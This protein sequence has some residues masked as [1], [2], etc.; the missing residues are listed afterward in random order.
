VLKASS[1]P[2]R[3]YGNRFQ[4][5]EVTSPRGLTWFCIYKAVY[6]IFLLYN[7]KFVYH[8]LHL[9]RRRV[10]S[11]PPLPVFFSRRDF[12]VAGT[13]SVTAVETCVGAAA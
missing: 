5:S 7:Y 6:F 1:A 10:S 9:L 12:F 2:P 11:H 3:S 4:P 8:L 13:G